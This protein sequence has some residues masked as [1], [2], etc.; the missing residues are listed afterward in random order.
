M[1]NIFV[2]V[3]PG[4]DIKMAEKTEHIHSPDED[5]DV[6][7][8]AAKPT[9]KKAEPQKPADHVHD[10]KKPAEHDHQAVPAEKKAAEKPA[11]EI[12]R[13]LTRSRK[14]SVSIRFSPM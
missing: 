12:R 8:H 6:H 4:E 10:E 7:E 11:A 2:G 1:G 13:R 14:N 9:D 5:K 3:K